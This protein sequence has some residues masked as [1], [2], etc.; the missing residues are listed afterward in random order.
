MDARCAL[1]SQA[2]ALARAPNRQAT[3]GSQRNGQ[4]PANGLELLG[5]VVQ[6]VATCERPIIDTHELEMAKEASSQRLV[7]LAERGRLHYDKTLSFITSI[8]TYTSILGL[9]PSFGISGAASWAMGSG[10]A[11]VPSRK[12]PA[13]T[14]SRPKW[15]DETCESTCVAWSVVVGDEVIMHCNECFA[16]L[17][18]STEEF[19][20]RVR[21]SR[22]ASFLMW[23][24]I[25]HSG[26]IP[27]FYCAFIDVLF[28]V[29][30]E[31]AS[32]I[33]QCRSKTG[34]TLRCLL[35][36][37]SAFSYMPE[38]RMLLG[39]VVYIRQ[40]GCKDFNLEALCHRPAPVVRLRE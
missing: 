22:L 7:G 5:L 28:G 1:E 32:V 4:K 19:R 24:R 23:A 10:R 40:L 34:A 14:L 37:R 39:Y 11:V 31:Q 2:L 8:L 33:A 35:T 38:G 29:G 9:D 13:T 6:A 36:L 27:R 20:E 30:Q 15:M 26:D 21:Q 3:D 25:I 17:F 18:W 16:E 12:P